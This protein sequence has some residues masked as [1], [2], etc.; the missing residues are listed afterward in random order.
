[1]VDGSNGSKPERIKQRGRILVALSAVL[2]V[3]VLVI[4][5]ALSSPGKAP[6]GG[7]EDDVNTS[8]GV[9]EDKLVSGIASEF[10]LNESDMGADWDRS[11][12]ITEIDQVIG[13]PTNLSVT[14]AAYVKFEQLNSTG[15]VHY[16]VDIMVLVFDTVDNASSFYEERTEIH[17]VDDSNIKP[18]YRPSYPTLLA[19]VSIGDRGALIDG[20]HITLGHEAKA[21]YFIDK[22]VVCDIIYHDRTSYDSLPNELLTDLA[23]KVNAK[24]A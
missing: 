3:A 11:E 13:Y 14:S 10:I 22:N 12:F 23:N 6:A 8:D 4:A 24:I 9:D 18:E 21:I 5:F 2:V 17:P 16:W 15:Q 1:M 7:N 19:N 20:P